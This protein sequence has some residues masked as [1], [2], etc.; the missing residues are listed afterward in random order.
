M[1][2]PGLGDGGVDLNPSEQLLFHLPGEGCPDRS[3][4]SNVGKWA[5]ESLGDDREP[6]AAVKYLIGSL[7]DQQQVVTFVTP[8]PRASDRGQRQRA[9]ST[10]SCTDVQ[11][12]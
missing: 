7:L 1:T 5:V 10:Q 9:T 11:D 12:C 6:S 4:V 2:L 8:G 3:V